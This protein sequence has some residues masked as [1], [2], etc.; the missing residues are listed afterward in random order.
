MNNQWNS[1]VITPEGEAGSTPIATNGGLDVNTSG[2]LEVKVDGST[3]DINSS[4]ELEAIG[5]GAVYEAGEGIVINGSTISADETVLATKAE[6]GSYATT[7]SVTTGLSAKQ[8]TI[9]DL[10]TIRSGAQAGASAVQ[11]SGLAPYATTASM[12]TA[13]AGKQDVISD[14]STIRSGAEAG[15]TALQPGALDDYV[16]DSDLSTALSSKQDTIS[17]LGTIR[18]GAAAGAS[19][20]QPG[21]LA[22]VATTGSY[23]DLSDKPVIPPG[24]VVDQTY[25]GTSANAQSG[26]AVAQA[27]GAI[28]APQVS[29]VVE[30]F[31]WA[32]VSYSDINT[33]LA[34][35]NTPVMLYDRFND[36]DVLRAELSETISTGNVVSS[37][38]FRTGVRIGTLDVSL[39]SGCVTKLT[40]NSGN[41]KLVDYEEAINT[42]FTVDSTLNLTQPNPSLGVLQISVV[43]PV[44]ASTSSDEN[45]VL[46]VNASGN[47][48]WANPA[49][50]TV[51]QSY[52]ASSTN[53]Q[54][55]TAVAGAISTK[56]DTL[57]AG[58]GITISNNVISS[59]DSVFYAEIDVTTFSEIKAAVNAGK[60]VYAMNQGN[61]P[62]T[63]AFLY[64]LQGIVQV[65]SVGDATFLRVT[66]NNPSYYAGYTALRCVHNPE[67]QPTDFW[68]E[69]AYTNSGLPIPTDAN[70]TLVTDSDGVATWV[71]TPDLSSYATTSAMNTA[72][73][74]KQDTISDLSTIRSGAAAG[75][76]AVQ[77][78]SLATVATTGDYDDL[79][80]KPTIPVVPST[81]PVV[82]GSNITITDGANN[83]TIAATD[84]T[85]TA[86]TGLTL[87]SGAFSVDTSVV[88]TQSDLSSYTP[89]ASLATVAT[90]GDY[91]DLSNRP[92]IPTV[93]QSYNA[94]STNAQSG[95][96][97]AGALAGLT[98]PVIGTVTIPDPTPE[99]EPSVETCSYCNGS[100]V[101]PN[102]IEGGMCMSCNGLGYID[103]PMM[104]GTCGGTGT[105]MDG[106][107]TCPD[108]GGSGWMPGG[109]TVPCAECGGTGYYSSD[110]T[111]PVCSGSGTVPAS[112][113]PSEPSEPSEPVLPDDVEIEEE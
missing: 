79:A 63:V 91:G 109:D 46:T 29:G 12:N 66:I 7:E 88:A 54:S 41:G 14:L 104:C 85:Y 67:S 82:A 13:L 68:E 99:P 86:G 33:C 22:T 71:N 72:L 31:D 108:C 16:T 44:P 39:Q 107:E 36:G 73:A 59:N 101:D 17:D 100:G 15:A 62:S 55:G 90:T 58:R 43:N 40:I 69:T 61:D 23:N 32:T 102:H 65:G 103:Q 92:T 25:D 78:S 11:P 34:N 20:V 70:K 64:Q 84:T 6:L 21:S 83:V 28:P 26:I 89:T 48:A 27:I 110:A 19:A 56:Q 81:K 37:Y 10:D 18:A 113:S 42:R 53:A 97:V 106:Q 9:S 51:D 1:D 105:I 47:A 24:V 8:D 94:S 50:V 5:G 52:N 35:G 95:A 49:A 45:K 111:C 60:T 75:A 57:T 87:S 112:E 38:I 4:G 2:E 30:E 76:T 98:I 74:G 93:D 77:P 3:I 80:N 96:A